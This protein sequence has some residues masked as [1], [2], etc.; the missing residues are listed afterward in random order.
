MSRKIGADSA[1]GPDLDDDEYVAQLLAKDAR[2]SSLRYSTLGT[3]AF[4]PLQRPSPRAPKPN[5][6]FLRNILRETDSHNASLKR[7]EEEEARERLR[8][9]QRGHGPSSGSRPARDLYDVRAAKRRKVEASIDNKYEGSGHSRRQKGRGEES[10]H[11]S[12]DRERERPREQR[13]RGREYD[14][15]SDDEE[16]ARRHK[17]SKS[18]R[19]TKEDD[20]SHRSSRSRRHAEH[21]HSSEKHRSS[22]DDRERRSHRRQKR[23]RSRSG[24]P[25]RTRRRSPERSSSRKG[26]L[27]DK[28]ESHGEHHHPR[29]HRTS[30]TSRETRNATEG[31]KSP[32]P[33]QTSPRHGTP[34]PPPQS[35]DVDTIEPAGPASASDSDSDSDPLESLIGPLPPSAENDNTPPLRSRGRGAYKSKSNTIDAHFAPDYDPALDIHPDDQDEDEGNTANPSKGLTGR[36]RPVAGLVTA[37][38]DD[39]DMALEALRDRALWRRKGADRL[40]AA[41]FDEGVIKKWAGNGA[42]AGLDGGAGGAGGAGGGVYRD[43]GRERDVADVKWVKRGEQRDWDRGKVLTDDGQVEIRPEW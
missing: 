10:R 25:S 33:R 26:T 1:N 19:H 43:T 41:G 29:K 38:D 13:R 21:N 11:L 7:K 31:G 16:K 32:H 2:D 6:R 23:H 5:T 37:E 36:R 9:L 40:R 34:E 3:N 15:N 27:K 12:H 8:V 20:R 30:T 39:W 24:S 22:D 4:I 14:E 35:R 17:S 28:D 18:R 42:F